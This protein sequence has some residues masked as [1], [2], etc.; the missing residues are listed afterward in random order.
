MKR[1][2]SP[3]LKRISESLLNLP[4][5][6]TVHA[7]LL[8]VVDHPKA[9]A[10]MLA[11]LI[12]EDQSLTARLIKMC[13]SSY[14]GLSTEVNSIE[15]AIVILGFDAVREMSLGISVISQF[16]SELGSG[17]LDLSQFWRHSSSTAVIAKY[18]SKEV[19]GKE[20]KEAFLGGLL[21]DIGKLILVQY[22]EREFAQ[23]VSLSKT[24]DKPLHIIENELLGVNHS[25]VGTWLGEKW[26]FPKGVMSSIE[27]HHNPWDAENDLED[28]ACVTLANILCK[29]LNQGFSG[30]IHAEITDEKLIEFLNKFFPMD[31]ENFLPSLE[32]K[33]GAELDKSDSML[34]QLLS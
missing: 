15:R 29:R 30:N 32:E 19:L 20:G 22:L 7:R 12:A 17:S 5:L 31:D 18:L 28:L 16:D 10:A 14:Y 34:R 21:H 4:T 2:Y 24:E 25:T 13:N 9:T 1:D 11:S 23:V 26:K 8:E 27:F 3:F 6:P 33:I